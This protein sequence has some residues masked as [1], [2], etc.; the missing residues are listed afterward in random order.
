MRVGC[1]QHRPAE[2][3]SQSGE[4]LSQLR[5]TATSD[6]GTVAKRT[7]GLEP[8]TF[9]RAAEPAKFRVKMV[10]PG[11]APNHNV[12][13]SCTIPNAR[14]PIPNAAVS[15]ATITGQ[16]ADSQ[17]SA[18]RSV[19]SARSPMIAITTAIAISGRV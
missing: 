3:I 11:K 18:D 8:A 9:G 7:T 10:K 13:L 5:L 1:Q 4:R 16:W 12:E 2:I 6:R 15:G 14:T 17:R 19:R